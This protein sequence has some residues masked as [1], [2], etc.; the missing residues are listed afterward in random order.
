MPY[1]DPI[2]RKEYARSRNP[3]RR[4]YWR[5]YARKHRKKGISIGYKAEEFA[6]KILKDS[7]R[8]YRPVD[9]SW[10]GKLVEVKTAIK[11]LYDTGFRKGKTYH[12]KFYLK[13]LRKTDLFLIILQDKNKRVEKVF[14]I[15]DSIF[16]SKNLKIAESKIGLYSNFEI[17]L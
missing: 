17:T 15:P 7:K 13:Q 16:K 8:I 10:E 4:A 3:L 12:W 2:K 9:L 11:R 1:A 14:L 6:L 5:E